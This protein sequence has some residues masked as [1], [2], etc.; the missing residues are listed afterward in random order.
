MKLPIKICEHVIVL[1]HELHRSFKPYKTM[2]LSITI[3]EHVIVVPHEH[4]SLMKLS[5]L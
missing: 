5:D 3:C 4:Y 2:K 1:P